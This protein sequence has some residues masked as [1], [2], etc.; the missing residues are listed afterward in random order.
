M[1]WIIAPLLLLAA[2]SAGAGVRDFAV[3]VSAVVSE[4]PL[5]VD[6]SWPPDATAEQYYV[7]R[8]PVESTYWGDPIA[9]LGGEAIEFTDHNVEVGSTYEYSFRK[10]LEFISETVAVESGTPVLFTIY[11][12]WG[13]GI[14]CHHGLGSY[15]VTG[16][17][18]TYAAGGAFGVREM[19]HF[20]VGT[21]EE[22]CDELLI[23]ITLDVFGEETT[24]TLENE[25]TSEMIAEGGPYESPRFGHILVGIRRPEVEDRGTVLLLVEQ[26]L[27]IPLSPEL[28]RLRLD[29]IGDGYRVRRQDVSPIDAV[30]DVKERIVTECAADPTIGTLFLFGHIPVPYSGRVMSAHIN[31]QGAWPA[32]VYYGELDAAWTDSIVCD[33]SATREANHN[34]PGDG[35]FDQT[36]LPSDVDLEVGRVDLSRMPAFNME[37]VD[38]YRRY[39][40][41]DHAHRVGELTA[42]ARGMVDDNAGVSGGLAFAATGWRNFATMFEARNVFD[43]DFFPDLETESYLWAYGCGPAGYTSCSGVGSTID[44]ATRTVKAT[45]TALYGSYFGDWDNSDNLLRAPLGAETHPLVCF[46][47]G[48]PVWHFYRMALGYTMGHCTRQTQNNSHEFTVGDGSRQIHIAL[49]GDPTLRMHV[50]RPPTALQLAPLDPAQVSLAWSAPT[51]DV[52]AYHIYRAA[53]LSDHFLRINAEPVTD[54]TFVDPAPLPGTNVYMVRALELETAASGSYYNLSQGVIDSL[55]VTAGLEDRDLP[56]SV[57]FRVHPN[58]SLGGAVF[59]LALPRDVH[60]R[61]R[62][63]DVTGAVVRTVVDGPLPAGEHALTWDGRGTPG[64]VYFCVLNAEGISRTRRLVRID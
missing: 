43:A 14:C 15:E 8:K 7:F 42:E 2:T 57:Q 27:A 45:F 51:G 61:L 25:E 38:L 32:D 26:S 20:T 54:T 58:P 59:H 24:W 53:G 46:W 40:D 22:P 44:F 21:P 18:V 1:R 62:I 11:D 50:V 41:K 60:A 17:G 33:T 16:C 5:R 31:H 56:R 52:E 3:E 36:F 47:A 12:S 48:R 34:V 19:T 49:M 63:L 30:P 39:L 37:E 23:S 35:K 55:V 13:D 6:F 64:G 9:T 4:N 29:L 28:E 10:S